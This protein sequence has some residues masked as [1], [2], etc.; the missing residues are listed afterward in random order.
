MNKMVIYSLKAQMSPK[1]WVVQEH[2]NICI[3]LEAAD[4]HHLILASNTLE[5]MLEK[6]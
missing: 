1:T 5:F 6:F 4:K 3:L 2:R